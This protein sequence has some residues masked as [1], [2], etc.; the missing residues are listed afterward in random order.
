MRCA[1]HARR[2]R[3]VVHCVMVARVLWTYV[4]ALVAVGGAVASRCDLCAENWLFI[5]G[6]GGRTGS[7]TVLTMFRQLPHVELAGEHWGILEKQREMYST[8]SRLNRAPSAFVGY[9]VDKH[10]FACDTQ[11]FVKNLV[12]GTERERLQSSTRVL[13][14]KE[15]RYASYPM[16]GFLLEMFPCARFI[17]TIRDVVGDVPVTAYGF[18]HDPSALRAQWVR[19]RSVARTIHSNFTQ[20]TAVFSVD[21]LHVDAFNDVLHTLLGVTNCSYNGIM[22]RNLRGAITQEARQLSPHRQTRTDPARRGHVGSR[23][24]N[25]VLQQ[26][27]QQQQQQ[28]EEEEEEWMPPPPQQHQ[29]I[30]QVVPCG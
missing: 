12:L 8:L 20:T 11:E 27:Q 7:T 9:P 30:H 14:F 3:P 21:H 23:S 1:T 24:T 17:F 10:A 28:K 19:E 18:R 13:G 5:L 4:F 15:I 29:H 2:G 16:L 26:Q 25:L 22:S 6:A